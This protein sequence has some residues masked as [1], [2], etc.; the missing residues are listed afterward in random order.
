MLLICC[1]FVIL[2][3]LVAVKY[4]ADLITKSLSKQNC[5]ITQE[6]CARGAERPDLLHRIL[7]KCLYLS[8][9]K[10]HRVV[11]RWNKVYTELH[12]PLHFVRYFSSHHLKQSQLPDHLF[13]DHLNQ[14]FHSRSFIVYY[15]FVCPRRE[16]SFMY[17]NRLRFI[18]IYCFLRNSVSQYKWSNF[19]PCTE[20]CPNAFH[21][22]L[23]W[24]RLS[25]R[26]MRGRYSYLTVPPGCTMASCQLHDSHD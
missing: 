10:R 14:K 15:C 18:E 4:W 20:F 21:S 13:P 2:P 12:W 3:S 9:S 16:A 26:Q 5:G 6:F 25:W 24:L 17:E 11:S 22:I 1:L 8:K 23:W 19:L 7:E